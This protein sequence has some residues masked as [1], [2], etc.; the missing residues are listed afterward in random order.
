[1]SVHG[2]TVYDMIARGASVHGEAPAIIQGE[3]QISFRELKRRVD[4]LAGGLA[5]RGI[6]KGE[7][8]CICLLYTSDAADEL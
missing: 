5:G 8:I 4:A 6:G 2:F 3:R 7:R 1:M